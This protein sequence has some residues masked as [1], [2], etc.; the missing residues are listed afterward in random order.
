MPDP[1]AVFLLIFLVALGLTLISFA[2]GV[3][4]ADLPVIG[5]GSGDVHPGGDFAISPTGVD[6]HADSGTPAPGPH[7]ANHG[8]SPFSLSTILAFLTWFGGAGYLLTAHFGLG[9]VAALMV[10]TMA[11]LG[12]ASIV[13]FFVARV[14]LRGQTPFLHEEDYRLEGTIGRLSVGIRDGRTGELVYS[15]AGTR[16]VASVRSADGQDIEQGAEV[17]VIHQEGGIAYVRRFDDLLAEG[18]RTAAGS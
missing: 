14:L 10:A 15:K 1:A 5:H 2:F 13:F 4:G 17:V 8:F 6:L 3:L 16:R 18:P 12:G 9:T 7:A 11:G